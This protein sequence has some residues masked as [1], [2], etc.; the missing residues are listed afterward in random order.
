MLHEY[1][2]RLRLETLIVMIVFS[3]YICFAN[4]VL[5]LLSHQSS[6][7]NLGFRKNLS[8]N[9]RNILGRYH[10]CRPLDPI[11][12]ILLTLVKG[13]KVIYL[14]LFP[15]FL[16]KMQ[17][18]KKEATISINIFFVYL[19]KMQLFPPDIYFF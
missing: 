16:K 19:K 17:R 8:A 13:K 7:T 12:N 3:I 18:F 11:P 14:P 4:M 1:T 10:V 5:E 15:V 6:P 2:N 9:S